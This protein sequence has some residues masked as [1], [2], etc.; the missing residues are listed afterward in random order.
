MET[1]A[2]SGELNSTS[3][4][5]TDQAESTTLSTF[6]VAESRVL[7]FKD[8]T[9]TSGVRSNESIDRPCTSEE[10]ERESEF[11]EPNSGVACLK[12]EMN[13][14]TTKSGNKWGRQSESR[15]T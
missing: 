11:R 10:I 15:L 8:P 13:F 2:R 9:F 6:L 7:Y 14:C 5:P 4:G 12:T 3:Q 1:A